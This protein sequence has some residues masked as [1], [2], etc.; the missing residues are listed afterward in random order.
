M[1]ELAVYYKSSPW[2]TDL[3]IIGWLVSWRIRLSGSTITQ[4]N[5]PCARA[6]HI[7]SDL[8][9]SNHNGELITCILLHHLKFI[10]RTELQKLESRGWVIR[11]SLRR[12]LPS[13]GGFPP[14]G[15]Y[16]SRFHSL[17]SAYYFSL[18][19]HAKVKEYS[20]CSA[21]YNIWMKANKEAQNDKVRVMVAIHTRHSR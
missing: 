8:K 20:A 4:L 2:K 16:G 5:F 7:I 1:T 6:I 14:S 13:V 18:L 21:I 10:H 15:A 11:A 9:F 3:K 12:R 17:N 19:L